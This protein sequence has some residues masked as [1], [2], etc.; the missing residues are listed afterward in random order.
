MTFHSEFRK[1]ASVFVQLKDG[2]AFRD[3]YEEV[4]GRF[5]IFRKKGK[6]SKE[7]LRA[8]SYYRP[9]AKAN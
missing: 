7:I 5:V 4:K 6:V 2:Q 3:N 9:T 8:I 1:G